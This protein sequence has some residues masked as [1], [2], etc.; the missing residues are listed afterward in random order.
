MKQNL[1]K[2]KNGAKGRGGWA[3]RVFVN[4]D[5]IYMYICLS[6]LKIQRKQNIINN[7]PKM[8]IE[9]SCVVGTRSL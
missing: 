7:A 5:K 3:A 1:P 4:F 6:I 8:S 9:C 2:F